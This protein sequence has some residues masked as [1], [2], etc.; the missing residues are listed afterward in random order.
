MPDY[1]LGKI[2]RLDCLSTGKCYIGSTAQP[3]LAKR[4]GDHVSGYKNWVKGGKYH[5]VSSFEI[6]KND[7]YKITLIEAFPCNS[8]DQL[9]QR[10]RYWTN[11]IQCVNKYRN[12]GIWNELGEKE[13]WKKRREANR[14]SLTEYQKQYRDTNA[15][16]L[17]AYKALSYTCECGSCI[18]RIIKSQHSRT[19]KHQQYLA[20]LQLTTN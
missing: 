19:Q 4:L 16:K 8:K 3:T 10:E 13:Y 2:Y 12:Q 14:D 15:D 6:I 17:K 1:Q 11:E 5:F 18:K 7:N 9:T 20:S